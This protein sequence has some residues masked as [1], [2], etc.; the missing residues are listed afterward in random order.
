MDG[1]IMTETE[2]GKLLPIKVFVRRLILNFVLGIMLVVLALG[3]GM[4]G[5]HHYEH[6]T[7]VDAFVNASMILSGMGPVSAL[8][9]NSGKIF[10]GC[11]A[12]FSGLTFIVIM[13]IIFAPIL[14]R[15]LRKAHLDVAG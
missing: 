5:Y 14:H 12:L 9:T 13:G 6:M 3:I 8:V 15:F 7:W 11:Y 1:I 4:I 2:K 10:A